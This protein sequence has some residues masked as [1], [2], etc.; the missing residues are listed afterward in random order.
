MDAPFACAG[1]RDHMDSLVRDLAHDLDREVT[2]VPSDRRRDVERRRGPRRMAERE[3][4]IVERGL[5]HWR[6]MIIIALTCWAVLGSVAAL[7]LVLQER[8]DHAAVDKAVLASAKAGRASAK[9]EAAVQLALSNLDLIRAEAT[10]LCSAIESNRVSVDAAH[11]VLHR[12]LVQSGKFPGKFAR[13]LGRD[14]ASIR[15]VPLLNCTAITT[16]PL[17]YQLPMPVPFGSPGAP[18]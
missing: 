3:Q 11:I 1:H 17:T 15:F 7:A 14:A 4:Q 13:E 18:K 9:A 5:P 16:N 2:D 8:N 10:G 12:V 6:R